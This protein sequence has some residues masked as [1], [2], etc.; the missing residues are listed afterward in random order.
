MVIVD[1]RNLNLLRLRWILIPNG[2]SNK[3]SN[4]KQAISIFPKVAAI[5][6][7]VGAPLSHAVIVARELGIP[8]VVGCGNATIFL[9]TGDHVV[10][11]GI[12]GYVYKK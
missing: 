2:W 4:F 9:K 8:A 6:T 1:H 11:D 5:I 10:V 12:N 7:D 3:L